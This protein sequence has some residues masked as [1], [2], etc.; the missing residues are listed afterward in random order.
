M[1]FKRYDKKTL[2]EYMRNRPPHPVPTTSEPHRVM[3]IEKVW[4]VK[5][6]PDCGGGY[7]ID[8][9]LTKKS[10]EI[11]ASKYE[12]IAKDRGWRGRTEVILTA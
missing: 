3:D 10:A 6:V 11:V 9:N 1:A 8:N 2:S 7:E 5:W 4:S 12:T